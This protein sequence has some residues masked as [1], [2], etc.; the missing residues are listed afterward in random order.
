MADSE[1]PREEPRRGQANNAGHSAPVEGWGEGHHSTTYRFERRRNG[2]LVA[3]V[4]VEEYDHGE[5]D[6]R[7]LRPHDE[8]PHE[9][10]TT[11]EVRCSSAD[12]ALY[13]AVKEWGVT[14]EG[15]PL[16][17]LRER[18]R[19]AEDEDIAARCGVSVRD[20]GGE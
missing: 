1:P 2:E 10:A 17:A 19:G 14:I 5:A 4:E 16:M 15:E 11:A 18:V 3:V 12:E 8:R 7:H 20:D 9:W 13:H 6:T